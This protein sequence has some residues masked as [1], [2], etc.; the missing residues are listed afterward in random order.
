MQH[1]PC[2]RVTFYPAAIKSFVEGVTAAII[3]FVCG[4]GFA[5]YIAWCLG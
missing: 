5:A 2:E 1:D 3:G 4:I